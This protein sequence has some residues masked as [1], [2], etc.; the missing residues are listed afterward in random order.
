[1]WSHR[2][3][4]FPPF[5]DDDLRLLQAVED[6]PV[7]QFIPEPCVETLAIS[8]FPRLVLLFRT[9]LF[10]PKGADVRQKTQIRQSSL[11]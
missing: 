9:Q 11:P 10:G 6:L 2:I 3:V 7:E 4:V 5:F 1:M 8:V